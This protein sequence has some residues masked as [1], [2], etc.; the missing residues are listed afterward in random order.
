MEE[1]EKEARWGV[2]G[3]V[4]EQGSGVCTG[5]DHGARVGACGRCTAG[6]PLDAGL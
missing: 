1:G 2:G 4:G 6:G 3:G 5:Q